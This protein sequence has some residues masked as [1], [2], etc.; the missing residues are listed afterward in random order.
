MGC[1]TPKEW[2]SETGELELLI[3]PA[4]KKNEVKKIVLKKKVMERFFR[5]IVRAVSLNK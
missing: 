3:G 2:K 5:I 1:Q 4:S